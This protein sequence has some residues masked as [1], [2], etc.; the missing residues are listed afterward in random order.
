MVD[1]VKEAEAEGF[2]AMWFAGGIG[3]DPLTVIAVA[4]RAT[5][6]IELGTS[7]V[8]TYPRHPVAMAQEASSVAAAIGAEGAGRF[9]L[10]I[11]VSHRPPVEDMLGIP[12]DRPGTN[13]REYLSV[14]RPLLHEGSVSFDGEFYKVRS[15]MAPPTGA[16]VPVL[17]AALAPVMLRAAGTLAE[18]TITWM[19]NARA[20]ESHVSPILRKAAADAGRDEPRI[21]VGLPVAVCDDEAEGRAEAAKQFAGY[22]TL[23][24]YRRILDHGAAEGPGDAAIVGDEASVTAQLQG[25]LDAGGTDVW[26]AIFPVGGDRRASRARTRELLRSLL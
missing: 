25:L 8:P 16:P 19:A 23:P 2:D 4:G 21:V 5:E 20:I 17:V 14:L 26:A 24:N 13:M 3:G 6:R 1:Q 7:V 10:G 15:Q 22:G 18:G 11:G 9:T 12:Y